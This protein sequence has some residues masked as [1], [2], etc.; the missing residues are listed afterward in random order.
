MIIVEPRQQSV[1]GIGRNPLRMPSPIV[2]RIER[3]KEK[4]MGRKG[5]VVGLLAQD[6]REIG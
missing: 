4:H 3:E 2:N 6:L 1:M 5:K